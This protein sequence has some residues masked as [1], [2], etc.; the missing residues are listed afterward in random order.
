MSP[1]S[2]LVGAW[3]SGSGAGGTQGEHRL[4]ELLARIDSESPCIAVPACRET[5][6]RFEHGSGE[7]PS[8]EIGADGLQPLFAR[9]LES[10]AT[11]G[12]CE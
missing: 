3:M 5:A 6:A 2:N 7:A 10:Q 4:D 9:W 11:P 1:Q 8:V 12:L